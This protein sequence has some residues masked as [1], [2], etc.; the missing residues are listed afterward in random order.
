MLA[1]PPAELAELALWSSEA[2]ESWDFEAYARQ[3]QTNCLDRYR[4]D[5]IIR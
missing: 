3:E 4:R 5:G 1:E 2:I